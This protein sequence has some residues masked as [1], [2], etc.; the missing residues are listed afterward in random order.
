MVISYHPNWNNGSY[1]LYHPCMVYLPTFTIGHTWMLREYRC[2]WFQVVMNHPGVDMNDMNGTEN[3]IWSERETAP[4]TT[5]FDRFLLFQ[6]ERGW[7]GKNSITDCKWER[8]WSTIT[9]NLWNIPVLNALGSIRK[10][11]RYY[12]IYLRDWLP[13]RNPW[14]IHKLGVTEM[15]LETT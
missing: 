2:F 1:I 8:H 13:I 9:P 6:V 7:D 3:R 14:K 10:H 15:I 4:K 5:S 12:P 11:H